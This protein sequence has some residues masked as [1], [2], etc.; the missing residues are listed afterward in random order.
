MRSVRI[1]LAAGLTLIV[2]AIGLVLVHSPASVAHTNGI[3]GEE[4][5]IAFTSHSATYCQAQEL[6]PAGTS[7]LR[8]SLSAFS[9]PRVRV[10]VS[11]AGHPLTSGEQESGWTSRVLTVPVRALP[12]AVPDATVCVSFSL[13]DEAVTAFGTPTSHTTAAHDGRRALA[14]RM[15]IEY[16]HPGRRSWASLAPGILN[17]MRF[18]R[19]GAGVLVVSL[20]LVLLV[21]VAALASRLVLEELS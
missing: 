3:P 11:A 10:V 8:L 13:H 21:A 17:R 2:L 6:L 20:A 19:A 4:H 18:G 12:R 5:R 14:G 1:A 16:L 7:A 9:G 15:W